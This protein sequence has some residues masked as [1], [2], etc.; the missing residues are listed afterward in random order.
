[1]KI[2][3]SILLMTLTACGGQKKNAADE[4]TTPLDSIPAN[5]NSTE[6]F[7]SHNTQQCPRLGGSYR[8]RNN[9]NSYVSF[10]QDFRGNI[11]FVGDSQQRLP[12]DGTPYTFDRG[13]IKI[14]GSCQNNRITLRTQMVDSP[15]RYLEISPRYIGLLG[16]T[17]TDFS[18]N[19]PRLIEYD[20]VF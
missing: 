1:M 16:L 11:V 5:N 18:Q 4:S 8:V 9:G 17:I 12:I 15:D 10:S 3:L 20:R 6:R 2:I 13:R 7:S 14:A 19:P